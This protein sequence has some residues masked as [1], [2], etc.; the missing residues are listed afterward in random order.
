MGL[1]LKPLLE[2]NNDERMIRF[3]KM[4]KHVPRDIIVETSPKFQ[5]DGFRWAPKLL[6]DLTCDVMMDFKDRTATVTDDGLRGNYFLY[7]LRCPG[8]LLWSRPFTFYETNTKCCLSLK[9]QDKTT[10]YTLLPGDAICF[11]NQMKI[12]QPLIGAII[13]PL[14]HG[15]GT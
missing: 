6:M 15:A 12:S 10:E 7:R 13:R 3:W 2:V 4:A 1:D 9:K 14:Q 8:P 11:S 5:V